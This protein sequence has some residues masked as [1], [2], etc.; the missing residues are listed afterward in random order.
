MAEIRKRGKNWYYRYI[1]A[2]GKRV[3]RKGCPDRRETLAMAAAAE[4]EAG[5]IRSGLSDSRA[6]ARRR[7]TARPLADHLADWHAYLIDKGATAK[8]AAS[9]LESARRV[10]ALSDGA[11]LAEIDTPRTAKATERAEYA[12]RLADRVQS[13]RLVDLTRDR[14][15]AALAALR[16]AGRSLATCNAHRTAIRGFSRWAWKDG[17]FS[18]D[19]LAGVQ[20]FNAAE[21]RRHDR[22]TLGLDELRNLVAAAQG[23]PPH[24]E[25]TGEARAL[26]YRLAVAT[27][28]RF[29]EI[30]SVMP[31][32]F[33]LASDRP[34]V[35]VAAGY[36][37]NGEPAR[38]PM[39]PDLAADLCPYLAGI[40]EGTPAF[41]C[42]RRARRCSGPTWRGPASPTGTP[43]GWSSTSTPCGASA[44]PWPTL[45]GSPPAWSNA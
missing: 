7:H 43:R 28:L 41:P 37:K 6:E 18:E 23:G 34:T 2:E 29:S 1:D 11:S 45:P 35:T 36:T 40:P 30:K 17:R 27:G 44:P 33:R 15:Q 8:H 14:V 39:P 31:G 5:R 38:L 22:R 24:Q 21:D 9:S 4:A 12:S 32:S 42:P 3:E 25:M 19:V 16:A 13:A 20:G 10:V 26:C